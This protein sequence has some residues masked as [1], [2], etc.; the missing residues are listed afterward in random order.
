MRQDF[1]SLACPVKESKSFYTFKEVREHA[2]ANHGVI[3][4][5]AIQGCTMLPT[6]LFMYCCRLC[7]KVLKGAYEDEDIMY[8]HIKNHSSFFLKCIY[9]YIQTKCRVCN[10]DI[11]T[12]D[13]IIYFNTY[14]FQILAFE[15]VHYKLGQVSAKMCMHEQVKWRFHPL[16]VQCS[17]RYCGSYISCLQ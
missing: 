9:K 3:L 12:Q 7:G 2:H 10:L 13:I 15:M 11:D 5:E 1:C 6:Y 14:T 8:D 16:I 4:E 17:A